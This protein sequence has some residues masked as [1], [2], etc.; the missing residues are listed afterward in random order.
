MNKFGQKGVVPFAERLSLSVEEASAYTGIG[1]TT[2]R[3]AV[4]SGALK[5]RKVGTQTIILRT[6]LLGW[7]EARPA[8]GKK[9][10]S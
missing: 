3:Q 9:M 6:D 2:L 1:T 4:A 5:A 7:S 10:V 8:A